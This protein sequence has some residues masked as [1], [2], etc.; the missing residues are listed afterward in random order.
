MYQCLL[1]LPDDIPLTYGQE[2]II[3]KNNTQRSMTTHFN[4]IARIQ[5]DRGRNTLFRF[6][7][8]ALPINHIR[9]KLCTYNCGLLEEP[10]VDPLID[11]PVIPDTTKT[12]AIKFI[13]VLSGTRRKGGHIR[14]KNKKK[15]QNSSRGFSLISRDVRIA[16][17]G[18]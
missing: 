4:L 3:F 6:F 1:N 15:E 16:V 12:N 10:Y 7:A 13:N 18:A 11:C 9:L 5:F 8:R 17:R 14:S 2:G